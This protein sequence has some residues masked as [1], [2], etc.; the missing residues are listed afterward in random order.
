MSDYLQILQVEIKLKTWHQPDLRVGKNN[1][2]TIWCGDKR[3]LTCCCYWCEHFIQNRFKVKSHLI[4][5]EL[6]KKDKLYL[7]FEI[8]NGLRLVKYLS[9]HVI[10]ELFSVFK[11]TTINFSVRDKPVYGELD[12]ISV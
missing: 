1:V 9:L 7:V 8:L 3:W 5:E 2:K 10:D 4:N 6:T 11:Q 12:F